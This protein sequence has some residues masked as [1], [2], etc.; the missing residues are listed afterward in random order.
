MAGSI[1]KTWKEWIGNADLTAELQALALDEVYEPNEDDREAA[2]IIY[3]ELCTRVSV[4]PLKYK[5]GDEVAALTSIYN[6][7]TKSRELI[8]ERGR[9]AHHFSATTRQMFE[10]HVRPFTGYWHGKK[11]DGSLRNHDVRRAFRQA[12]REL[13]PKLERFANLL[14]VLTDSQTKFSSVDTAQTSVEW[15]TRGSRPDGYLGTAHPTYP[16]EIRSELAQIDA[17][18]KNAK[19][20]TEIGLIGLSLSGGGIRSA[21][22]CL[23]VVQS[24]VKSDVFDAIDYLSTVSGGGYFGG[25]LS[26]SLNPA[27]GRGM[28]AK[29]LLVEPATGTG[30]SIFVRW[31]RN[32][33]KYLIGHN[34]EE[35]RETRKE[36]VRVFFGPRTLHEYYR[37]KLATAYLKENKEDPNIKMSELARTDSK[38][39]YPIIN[40]AIN[41][42]GSENK[43]LRGRDSDFFAI[44]PH[45]I[46][47]VSTGYCKAEAMEEVHEDMD[48]ASA[49]ATSGAAISPHMGMKTK[50]PVSKIMSAA[51]LRLG[52]WLPNPRVVAEGGSPG[53]LSRWRGKYRE[54]R[55]R[56]DETAN[57]VNLA[58]GGFVE[59]LGVYELLRRQCNF[60]VAVDGECDEG[61]TCA[62]LTKAIRL[63]KID[64]G[65]NIDIDFSALNI[66]D[67]G[68]SQDHFAFGTISYPANKTGYLL[69]IKSSVTGNESSYVKEYREHN[70]TF[71]HQTTADQLFDEEQFE[72]YRAL[73]EHAMDDLFT[74]ELIP[75][76]AFTVDAWVSQLVN[77]LLPDS[78]ESAPRA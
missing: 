64:F 57:H 70:P 73:G 4:A 44:T 72:A 10:Q 15:S 50:R 45:Y 32:N 61:R 43:E 37:D 24:L 71:P 19:V 47:S 38:A 66:D 42:P 60:I 8:A 14:Q 18:R 39:P 28:S 49:V 30:D 22:F 56:L 67:E 78:N 46:G 59:N 21:T 54:F 7:F 3:T 2:W 20:E 53:A 52:M 77:E 58:D 76:G 31:L 23:G 27:P 51:N 63:A 13:Q 6:V 65:V 68:I 41:L 48:L 33:S 25:F 5:E 69:Y 34:K 29:S 62:A 35:K 26:A 11:E 17:R 75:P 40:T 36:L 12:L 1:P 74:R 55:G 9:S 16:A